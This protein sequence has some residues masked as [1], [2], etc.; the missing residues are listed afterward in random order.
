MRIGNWEIYVGFPYSAL[1]EKWDDLDDSLRRAQRIFSTI[2]IH[3]WHDQTDEGYM[4][5]ISFHRKKYSL[6][7]EIDYAHVPAYWFVGAS[8]NPA[9]AY[10]LLFGFST[11]CSVS[12]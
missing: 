12:S 4:L 8:A 10:Q 5:E 11:C 1:S 2:G 9:A 6:P 3:L 7:A